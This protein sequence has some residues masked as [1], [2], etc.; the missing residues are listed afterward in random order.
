MSGA[1]RRFRLVSGSDEVDCEQLSVDEEHAEGAVGASLWPCASA[2]FLELGNLEM[3]FIGD[4]GI[5]PP[6][7][8]VAIDASEASDE[9]EVEGPGNVEVGK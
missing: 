1:L 9:A 7:G 4:W 2:E 6:V 3:I 8:F 5:C